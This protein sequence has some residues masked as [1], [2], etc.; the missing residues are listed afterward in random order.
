MKDIVGVLERELGS[1][2]VIGPGHER[3]DDYGRDESPLP[4]FLP[5]D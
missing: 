2:A 5:P 4:E 1:Q 3:L